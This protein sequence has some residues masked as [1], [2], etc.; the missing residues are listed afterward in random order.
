M[1]MTSTTRPREKYFRTAYLT[2]CD[3]RALCTSDNRFG[4]KKREGLRQVKRLNLQQSLLLHIGRIMGSG[5]IEI[6]MRF[7]FWPM[8]A[9]VMGIEPVCGSSRFMNS[10]P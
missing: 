2:R 1:I 4:I 7:L 6:P 8:Q 3:T 10:L 9:E 5:D